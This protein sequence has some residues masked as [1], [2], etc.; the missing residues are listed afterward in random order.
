[1]NKSELEDLLLRG[2][3]NLLPATFI[4]DKDSSI[5]TKVVQMMHYWHDEDLNPSLLLALLR[6]PREFKKIRSE[7]HLRRLICAEFFYKKK[8][9]KAIDQYPHKRHLFVKLLPT[10]LEFPFG[11]KSVL[12]MVVMFNLMKQREAFE[13]SPILASVRN[14]IP[15]VHVIKGSFIDEQ[16][17]RNQV[18][19]VYLEIEREAEPS[20]TTEEIKRLQ[21]RLPVELKGCIEELVPVT[22]MRRNEEE[23]YRNILTLRDQLK[24]IKDIPQTTISFEEQTQF[25]L[26]FTIVLLRVVKETTPSVQEL[27]EYKHPD[28]MFIPDRVDRVGT[29]RNYKKEA[30]VFRLQLSKSQ[31]FRKDRSVNLYKARQKVISMLVQAFGPV[32]DYNGG[33]ILKQNERLEDFLSLMPKVYDEFFLENFFYSIT[34]IAMQSILPAP[35]V[36][37]WFLSLAELLEKEL[38]RV[39]NYLLLCRQID[40]AHLVIVRA[41]DSSFKEALFKDISQLNIPSLELAFSEINMHGAFCF[42]FLYRPSLVGKE[43][44]FC[45][46]VKETLDQWSQTINED[47]VLRIALFG[48][49]PNLDPRITKADHSYIILNM[50]FDGLTRMSLEGKPELA[51]AE[52]YTTNTNYTLYTFRLRESKWSNG[53]PITAYDFEYSW[54]HSLKPQSTSVFSQTFFLIKNARLAKENKVPLDAVGIRVVDEK[55]LVVEFEYPVPYFLFVAAHWTYSLINQAIDQKHPGWAYQAGETYVC[56]G[57]FK[58]L[59][60]KHSRTVT[61][62]KNPHY[63]DVENVNLKKISITLIER[64]Q[65]DLGMLVRD[66]VDL[67]GRPMTAFPHCGVHHNLEDVERVSFAVNG[68]LILCFNTSQFPF[69]NKKIRRAFGLCIPREF[70]EHMMPHEYYGEGFSLLPKRLSLHAQS[71]FPNGALTEARLSLQQ[72]LEE[73]GCDKSNFPRLALCFY[74][75]HQRTQ[76]YRMLS[77]Q[78]KE[79]LGIDVHL[80]SL[81]WNDYGDRLMKGEYQMGS[82]ELKARWPDPLHV[83]EFFEHKHDLLNLTRWEHPYFQALLRQAKEA[84]TLEE[85]NCFLNQAEAFLA[86][87]MPAVPLYQ[88]AGNYLKKKNLNNVFADTFQIDFKWASKGEGA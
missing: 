71:L 24:S 10:R 53:T 41:E 31:F 20:F 5:I 30:T 15:G 25:D 75:G 4:D 79:T 16:D 11:S 27:I 55:T 64:L 45:T 18:H 87:H 35:L 2:N 32:R 23:V 77:K 26:F 8:V 40:E 83:L 36:K 62:E 28:V 56:N 81:E 84:G 88:L 9:I 63:W 33:L 69:G 74:A 1:M 38:S 80:K 54:K 58:L 52:S 14:I 76:L 65:D 82:L 49:E 12:G 50:L 57:P 46:L 66:E 51:I 67:L 44:N 39:E 13:E 22:F 86:E 6:L 85:R 43:R 3:L 37:E 17:R 72:G 21:D 29:I 42:G 78:W 19:S 34:P 70:M 59:E 60:W 73:L 47:Q 68:L 7:A 61:V 48:G